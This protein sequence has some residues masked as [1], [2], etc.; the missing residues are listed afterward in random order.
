LIRNEIFP[1]RRRG[2]VD[3]LSMVTRKRIHQSN[4]RRTS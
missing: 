1:R 4:Y 3:A 2:T